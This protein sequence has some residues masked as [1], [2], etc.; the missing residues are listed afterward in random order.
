MELNET[1]CAGAEECGL[2]LE[3]CPVNVFKAVGQEV[4]VHEENEDECTLCDLCT[5]KCRCNALRIVKMY[6]S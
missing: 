4:E 6:E 3:V 2:C 1:L 5:Q